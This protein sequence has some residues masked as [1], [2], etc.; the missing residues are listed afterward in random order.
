M[1]EQTERRR[2]AIIAAVRRIPVG[3]VSSYG[4]I[5]EIAGIPRGAREVGRVLG[6]LPSGSDVP[7]H[8]VLNAAG[9]IHRPTDSAGGRLQVHR[10]QEEGV[11]IIHGKVNMRSFAWQNSLDEALWGPPVDLDD[12]SI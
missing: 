8:R 7:W 9:K 4:R 10:L 1:S 5:A 12:E 2:R 3:K 11:V 6:Q